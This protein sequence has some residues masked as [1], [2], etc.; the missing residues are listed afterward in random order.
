M[1]TVTEPIA[2]HVGEVDKS[3]VPESSVPETIMHII[4]EPIA[5]HVGEADKSSVPELSVPETIMH[6]ITEPVAKQREA[7]VPAAEVSLKSLLKK[8]RDF[9]GRVQTPADEHF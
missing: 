1:H 5:I 2:I 3:S 4:T 6:T 8:G 7:H 9:C